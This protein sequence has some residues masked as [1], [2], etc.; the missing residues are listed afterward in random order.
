[1][2]GIATQSPGGAKVRHAGENR[3]PGDG[4]RPSYRWK[5]VSRL[6][7]LGMDPGFHRG[8]DNAWIPAFAGMTEGKVDCQSTLLEPLGF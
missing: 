5:T 3:H 6:R 4:Q 8:D 1:M 2:N 7:G